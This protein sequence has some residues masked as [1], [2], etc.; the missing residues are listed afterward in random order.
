MEVPSTA[1]GAGDSLPLLLLLLLLL[2]PLRLMVVVVGVTRPAGDQS[3]AVR[4]HKY[5]TRTLHFHIKPRD[6]TTARRVRREGTAGCSI[7]G[8]TKN[9]K[10]RSNCNLPQRTRLQHKAAGPLTVWPASGVAPAPPSPPP[11]IARKDV[12]LSNVDRTRTST[13]TNLCFAFDEAF[14]V[15]VGGAPRATVLGRRKTGAQRRG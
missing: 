7:F 2:P 13:V 4:E 12:P 14:L 9:Q 8:L 15:F 1:E 10:K 11:S 6:P 5:H 3:S